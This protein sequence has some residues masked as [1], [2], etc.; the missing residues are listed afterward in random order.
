MAPRPAD[1][2]ELWNQ[3]ETPLRT[4]ETAE[5]YRRMKKGEKDAVKD[6]GS[7]L[8]GTLKGTRRKKS[9]VLS[10][11]MI[12]LDCD[13]LNPSFFDEYG[14]LNRFL[15]IVYTTPSHTPEAPRAR[16]LAP[17]TRDVTPE[18]Y[19]AVARYLADEI[20]MEMVDPCSFE[21]NQLMYWPTATVDGEYICRRY[22]GDWL[23]P[24]AYLGEHPAGK[25]APPCLLPPRKKRMWSGSGRSKKTR[26]PRRAPSASSAARTPCRR[27]CGPSSRT[28]MR[29][30]TMPGAGGISPPTASPRGSESL[31]M[32]SPS[33]R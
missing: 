14:F 6:K 10:R 26:S 15:S 29:K 27:P 9:D 12:T 24:D 3:L 7:F 28:C 13:K 17:L 2:E 1:A 31:K 5:Q 33:I 16:V 23:D 25:S 8:A 21:I 19:N 4:P 20:G 30:P 18:E 22:E 11:S 32:S